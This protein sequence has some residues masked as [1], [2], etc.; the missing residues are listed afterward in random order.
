VCVK[1]NTTGTHDKRFIRKSVCVCV[2]ECSLLLSS[3]TQRARKKKEE[4]MKKGKTQKRKRT[5]SCF[6]GDSMNVGGSIHQTL[7]V[8]KATHNKH[9]GSVVKHT[10]RF[11]SP[12][13]PPPT[14]LTIPFRSMERQ[15]DP[16][17]K[18]RFEK[19]ARH[20]FPLDT[21]TAALLKKRFVVAKH[22]LLFLAGRT[23]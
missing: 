12:L 22:S 4:A 15:R 14:C 2:C 11:V 1:R 8:S 23:L 21:S 6:D 9:T 13:T 18:A 3:S 16:R 5:R 10:I 19:R 7:Y 17:A 20:C